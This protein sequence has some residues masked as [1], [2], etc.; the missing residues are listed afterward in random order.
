MGSAMGQTRSP[1]SV[2]LPT[3]TDFISAPFYDLF[4]QDWYVPKIGRS[5]SLLLAGV[6]RSILEVGAGTGLI[7]DGFLAWRR[8]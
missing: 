2:E 1:S 5:L 3:V 4:H 6:R 8:A 7:T